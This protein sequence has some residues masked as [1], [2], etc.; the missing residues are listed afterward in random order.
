[1]VKIQKNRKNICRFKMRY[2][3]YSCMDV[4]LHCQSCRKL[5]QQSI[6]TL[7]DYQRCKL[8]HIFCSE[9]IKEKMLQ[10][11]PICGQALEFRHKKVTL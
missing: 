11:C 6:V 7:E 1:M 8:N 4:F 10:N 9:C 5:V 2:P 3:R